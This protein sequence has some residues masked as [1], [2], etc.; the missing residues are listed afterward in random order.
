MNE[1]VLVSVIIPVYNVKDYLI[2]CLDSVA[3]QSFANKEVILVDDGST[4]NSG[5]ICDVYATK[6]KDFRVIH[7]TCLTS[8]DVSVH[9]GR[10]ER[11]YRSV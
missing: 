4:D 6:H 8:V 7:K 5:H 1:N 3:T 2:D 9:I 10:C 11:A